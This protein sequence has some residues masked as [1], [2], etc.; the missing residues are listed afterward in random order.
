MPGDY[1][2]M[3]SLDG[4]SLLNNFKVDYTSRD[5]FPVGWCKLAGIR[6]ASI[7][8]TRMYSIVCTVI[9]TEIA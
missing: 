8:S 9:S 7:G 5:I 3:L 2:I 4:W 6:I 1:R